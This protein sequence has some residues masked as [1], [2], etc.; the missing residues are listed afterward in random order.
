M[1][2]KMPKFAKGVYDRISRV[3]INPN[4]MAGIG[5]FGFFTAI[6]MAIAATPKAE[7]MIVD[8]EDEKGDELTTVEKIKAGWKPFIPTIITATASG[9][10]IYGS[11][12]ANTARQAELATM[13]AVSQAIAKKYEEK[14][15]EIVG[16]DKAKEIKA[17]VLKETAKEQ[18][19]QEAIKALPATQKLSGSTGLV[20]WWDS[21]TN[22]PFYANDNIMEQAQAR[23]H[24]RLYSLEPYVTADDLYDEL[25]D[26]GVYPEL[27]P[28]AIT[29]KLAWT[30]KDGMPEFEKLEYGEWDDGTPC[31]I[32]SFARGHAPTLIK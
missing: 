19:A 32:M 1:G 5:V 7:D 28:T 12:K 11:C 24:K 21:L 10:L 2:F 3:R 25:N 13:C 17:E 14:T 9:A 31:K 6:G 26:L 20:P 16:E 23:L 22:T 15:E 18:S 8:A 4:L 29:N 30:I 27:K